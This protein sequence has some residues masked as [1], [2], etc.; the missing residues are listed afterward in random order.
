MKTIMKT[1]KKEF[2]LTKKLALVALGAT[3]AL[4]VYAIKEYVSPKKTLV[5]FVPIIEEHGLD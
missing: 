3:A 2:S 4:G 1:K 5:V